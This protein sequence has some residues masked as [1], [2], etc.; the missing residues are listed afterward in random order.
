MEKCQMHVWMKAG[1]DSE[2]LT[3]R[4]V[5]RAM[6]VDRPAQGQRLALQF[7][8]SGMLIAVMPYRNL[9]VKRNADRTQHPAPLPRELCCAIV[10]RRMHAVC[11][12]ESMHVSTR[13]PRHGWMIIQQPEAPAVGM[14]QDFATVTNNAQPVFGGRCFRGQHSFNFMSCIMSDHRTSIAVLCAQEL[15]SSTIM[16]MRAIHSDVGG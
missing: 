9:L 7:A 14:P 8:S 13:L 4:R 1:H 12:I 15:S 16:R 10:R 5:V 11:D 2:T 3:F 6:G